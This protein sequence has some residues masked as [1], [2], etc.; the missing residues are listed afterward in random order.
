MESKTIDG[1]Y[2]KR[3]VRH[4]DERGYFAELFKQGEPGF[5][6]IAQTSY[7]LIKPGVVKA[8]HH[9]DYWET[10]VVIEGDAK[11][12]I[13]DTRDGS[14]TKG[15]TQVIYAGQNEPV[16]VSIP[17][18]VAHGYKAVGEKE[19]GML[20]HAEEAYDP[21]RKDQIGTIPQDSADIGFDW[22]QE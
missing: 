4:T 10:W 20:Y 12:V 14:P 13:H 19:C 17:P 18:N 9:H 7:S 1:V 16:V 2:V 5:H 3:I 8:F 22:K 15:A 11:I 6:T 21:S